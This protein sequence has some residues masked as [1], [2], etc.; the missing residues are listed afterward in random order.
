MDSPTSSTIRIELVFLLLSN[1]LNLEVAVLAHGA[2][3]LLHLLLDPPHVLNH[4]GWVTWDMLCLWSV[5]KLNSE[6]NHL[7][8]GDLAESPCSS[9]NPTKSPGI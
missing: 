8:C 7:G 9:Y 4:T 2:Q 6:I 5:G 3:P 1:L